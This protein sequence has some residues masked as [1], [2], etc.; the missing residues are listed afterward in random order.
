PKTGASYTATD[1]TMV[2]DHKLVLVAAGA[3]VGMRVSISIVLGGLFLI[4][5]LGPAALAA[6]AVNSPAAAWRDIGVWLGAPLMVA[7]GLTSLAFQWRTVGRAFG[8]FSKRGA[9]SRPD[10]EVPS[11]WLLAGLCVGGIGVISIGQTAFGIPWPYG[12]A[13]VLLSFIFSLA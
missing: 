8:G 3:I 12:L 13:A 4:Y 2:L 6:G 5:V 1:W 11:W 9:A 10:A 7:A